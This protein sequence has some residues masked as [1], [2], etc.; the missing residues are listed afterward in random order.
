MSDTKF[1][2][3]SKKIEEQ[4]FEFIL[5]INNHIICQRYLNI[6]DFNEKSVNS[7]E[8]KELM[9][10]ICGMNNGDFG[11]LGIIPNYLK[12][13]SKNYLWHNYNPYSEQ[14][15][16]EYKDIFEK[17]DDFQFEIRI[18]KKTVAKS[19]FSGNFFPQK[20]RYA[21]DIKEIIPAIM[22][23]MRYYLSLKEYSE[24]TA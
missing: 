8:M 13:K 20:V 18:D 16:V 12:G 22:G 1:I 17:P 5:Y 10:S 4:R 19:V 15:E 7:Y 3:E 11:S 6:R 23:E 21:V 2:N 14:E 24:V 9:D